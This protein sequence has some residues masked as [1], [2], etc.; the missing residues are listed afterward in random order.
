MLQIVTGQRIGPYQVTGFLGRGAFAQV[1]EA[2]DATGRSVALKLGDDS[3]G[4][5][6]LKRFREITAQRSPSA[7]SPDETPAEAMFL[8]P[9]DGARS[10]LLDGAEVDE[11]LFKEARLLE[12]A[13]GRGMPELH[14]VIEVDR[15]PVLVMQKLAGATLRERIRSLEGVKL[16]WMVE[17]TYV[18]ERIQALG[19]TCH[20]DVKPENVFVC[21]DGA[22]MLLD[23]VPRAERADVVVTTPWYNPFLRRDAKGDSQAVGIMLYELLAGA[24]PF[25][26]VPFRYA[27]CAPPLDDGEER[28]LLM[29]LFLSFPK[30]RELNPR[31]PREFDRVVYRVLADEG[32]GLSDLRLDLEDFLLR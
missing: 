11:M 7:I 32:Y 2:V 10:E 24:L 22:I 16:Q 29:S 18:L 23:P 25:E 28:D 12:E 5:R 8:D 13:G 21:D 14:D 4:G 1:F 19:W 9:L 17:L 26:Q 31:C 15:R 27:G 6:F 20:G 30:P 3:G